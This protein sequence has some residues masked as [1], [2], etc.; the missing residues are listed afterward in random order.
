MNK[1]DLAHRYREYTRQGALEALP[2]ADALV[3]LARGERPADAEQLIAGIAKSALQSDLLHFARALEAPS[4]DLSADVTATLASERARAAHVRPSP[5][6]R[7]APGRRRRWIAATA[8]IA[9]VLVVAIGFVGHQRMDNRGE[10][11]AASSGAAASQVPDRIFAALNDHA[12]ATAPQGD[13]IFKSRF[14]GS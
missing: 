8:G 9:A 10:E 7:V 12:S 6:A 3:A 1:S 4:A 5:G 11:T 13:V 14:S 2:Q